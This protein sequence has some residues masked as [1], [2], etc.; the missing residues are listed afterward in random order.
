MAGILAHSACPG[1]RRPSLRSGGQQSRDLFFRPGGGGALS[2]P[3]VRQWRHPRPGA[4]GG[5]VRH[6]TGR[7][8]SGEIAVLNG[9]KIREYLDWRLSKDYRAILAGLCRRRPL[10]SDSHGPRPPAPRQAF[11][12]NCWGGGGGGSWQGKAACDVLPGRE[13]IQWQAGLAGHAGQS[14]SLHSLH[15]LYQCNLGLYGVTLVM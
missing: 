11:Y 6:P 7:G 9:L 14:R 3:R 10:V 12:P 8:R 13:V 4:G 1:P 15:E 2:L 5:A